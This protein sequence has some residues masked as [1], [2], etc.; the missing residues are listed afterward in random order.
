LADELFFG[1]A[2]GAGK[3]AV[4]L[5][6]ALTAHTKSIIFRR[7]YPQLK[8]IV[9]YSHDIV[10]K[11]GRFNGQGWKLD[12]GRSLEFGAVQ[13]EHDVNRDQGRAHDLKAFDELSNFTEFQ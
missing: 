9:T 11:R 1:G 12:D 13:Y 3:T 8:D 7:E 4:L 6:L 2:A 5:G 10:G